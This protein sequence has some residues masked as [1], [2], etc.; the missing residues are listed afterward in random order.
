MRPQF[1]VLLA[2]GLLGAVRVPAE[3]PTARSP[4]P[5]V[6]RLEVWAG[7][8]RL[9]ET[10]HP[11]PFGKSGKA[12]YRSVMRMTHGG[13]VLESRGSGSGPDGL[14]TWTELTVHDPSTGGYRNHYFDSMGVATS[15][16]TTFDGRG[17]KGSWSMTLEG[18]TYQCRF[19][20]TLGA[21]GKTYEYQWSYSEDGQ[22]W[23]PWLDGKGRRVGAVR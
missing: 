22:S 17:L 18:R 4:G 5:E 2:L 23:K 21:D 11:T 12:S 20:A 13:W 14:L 1:I 9:E 10:V 16:A 19:T 7:K 6:K 15:S 8:W 3:S